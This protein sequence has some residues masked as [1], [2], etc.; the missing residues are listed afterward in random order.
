VPH[1]IGTVKHNSY[2]PHKGSETV[3]DVERDIDPGKVYKERKM[4]EEKRVR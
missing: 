2:L 3:I 1:D 4:K